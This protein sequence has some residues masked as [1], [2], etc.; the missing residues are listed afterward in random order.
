MD[1]LLDLRFKRFLTTKIVSVVYGLWIGACALFAV[2]WV[3]AGLFAG[4]QQGP[5]QLFGGIFIAVFV[6]PVLLVMGRIYL[7]V[8]VVLFRIA[9]NIQAYAEREGLTTV[10]PAM[11]DR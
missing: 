9:E 2:G 5:L 8:I 11:R 10:R 3:L 7:E 4:M 1:I 6:A